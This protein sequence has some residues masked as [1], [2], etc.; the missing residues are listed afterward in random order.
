MRS[1]QVL[2]FFCAG[3]MFCIPIIEAVRSSGHDKRERERMAIVGVRRSDNGSKF[4][5]LCAPGLRFT[6]CGSNLEE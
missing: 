2:C 6:E 4:V 5:T 1:I 3:A